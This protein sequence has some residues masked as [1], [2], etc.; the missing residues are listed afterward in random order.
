MSSQNEFFDPDDGF[1]YIFSVMSGIYGARFISHWSEVDPL[2]VRQIWKEQLGRFL[3]YRPS[4]D[5]ALSNLHGEKPPSAITFRDL[6]NK[7][8][9][10]PIT[11][12]QKFIE[13]QKTQEE[14]EEEERQRQ[15]G[16]AMLQE[17]KRKYRNEHQ[18]SKPN[19]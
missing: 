2:L 1:D 7:G 12:S 16:L 11:F 6:C 18:T 15:K 4:L 17:L 3:T 14:L 8:P 13:R 5:F 9:T 19:P 10:I